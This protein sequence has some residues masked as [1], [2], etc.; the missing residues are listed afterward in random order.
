MFFSN[1]DGWYCLDLICINFCGA[2]KY[3]LNHK[4]PLTLL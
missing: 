3:T 4:T 1:K 2:G